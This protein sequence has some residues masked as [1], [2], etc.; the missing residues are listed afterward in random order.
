MIPV[1]PPNEVLYLKSYNIEELIVLVNFDNIFAVKL[2]HFNTN[3]DHQKTCVWSSRVAWLL[4]VKPCIRYSV[5]ILCLLF[6]SCVVVAGEAVYTVVALTLLVCF[7][8][9]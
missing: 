4:L 8:S 2:V 1:K 7:L 3:T 9:F 6:T 5:E